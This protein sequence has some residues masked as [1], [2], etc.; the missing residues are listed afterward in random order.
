VNA[1]VSLLLF[2]AS[3]AWFLWL[4]RHEP[5]QRRPGEA[6]AEPAQPQPTVS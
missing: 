6:A 2:L 4:G 1:W 5:R 3:V